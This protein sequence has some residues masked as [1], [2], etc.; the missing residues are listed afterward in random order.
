MNES[1]LSDADTGIVVGAL[2]IFVVAS[3]SKL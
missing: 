2:R 1:D 3:Y